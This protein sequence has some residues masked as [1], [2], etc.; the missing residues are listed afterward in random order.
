MFLT[1]LMQEMIRRHKA[2]FYF[3]PLGMH[4]HSSE[5]LGLSFMGVE[6]CSFNHAWSQGFTIMHSLAEF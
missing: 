2:K 6:V 4:G 1:A 3:L 5:N